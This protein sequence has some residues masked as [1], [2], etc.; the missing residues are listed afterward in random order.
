MDL[1]SFLAVCFY[2][3]AIALFR[4]TQRDDPG[5]SHD[6]ASIMPGTWSGTPTSRIFFEPARKTTTPSIKPARKRPST[7]FTGTTR[8]AV[9]KA[10]T[11]LQASI[12]KPTTHPN[13]SFHHIAR[14]QDQEI[15]P[16]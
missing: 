4:G 7:I 8:Q 14:G 3:A 12:N 2:E 11:T 6:T 5:T 16:Q 13:Q 10:S 15:L 1:F 9:A